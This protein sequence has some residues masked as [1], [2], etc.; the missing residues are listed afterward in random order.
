[1]IVCVYSAKARREIHQCIGEKRD[2]YL[3]DLGNRASDGQ[4]IFGHTRMLKSQVDELGKIPQSAIHPDGSALLPYPYD[5]LPELIDPDQPEDDTSSCSLAEAL[6]RQELFV[7]QA[8]VTPALQILWEFFR[9]GRLTWHGAFVNLKSGSMRPL[10][11][12]IPAH[13]H[14]LT[15]KEAT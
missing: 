5:P 13:T 11:V 6:E 2:V 1:M 12:P 3:L 10:P 14:S 4:V 7:N 15:S 8:V 9:H